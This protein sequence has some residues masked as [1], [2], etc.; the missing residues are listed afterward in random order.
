MDNSKVGCQDGRLIDL[1]QDL[2]D[3]RVSVLGVSKLR[4]LQ[5]QR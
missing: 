1:A 4:V 5:P 2:V 3:W